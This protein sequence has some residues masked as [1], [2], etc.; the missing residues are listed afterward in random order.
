MRD[1]KRAQLLNKLQRMLDEQNDLTRQGKLGEVQTLCEQTSS[2]VEEI[3]RAGILELDEFSGERKRL[4]QSYENLRLTLCGQKD[5]VCRELNRIR[6]GRRTLGVYRDNI[7][8][9]RK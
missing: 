6:K 3:S 5:E 2:V 7:Q 9:V 8:V 1:D 4:A